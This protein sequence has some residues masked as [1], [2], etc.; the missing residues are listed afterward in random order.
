MKTDSQPM[1]ARR[2]RPLSFDRDAALEQAMLTFW[3]HG[4]ETSS[5][6]DLTTAMGITAPSLYTAFGDKRRLFLEAVE[7]YRGGPEAAPDMI[8][9]ASDAHDAARALLEGAVERFT[10]R[11]TP[12]GCLMATATSSCSAASADVQASLAAIRIDTEARLRARIDQDVN[13]GVLPS[14]SDPSILAASTMCT[15]QGLST[16]ARDGASRTKLNAIADATLAA[17]PQA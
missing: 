17:W 14:G 6:A 13:S 10:G 7:L 5:I 8:A 16:L 4:Y 11:K 1:K 9:S 15:I 12:K 2:G 3:R